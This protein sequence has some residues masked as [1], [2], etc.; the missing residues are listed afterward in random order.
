MS[1]PCILL[2]QT[3]PIFSGSKKEKTG[4]YIKKLTGNTLPHSG[5]NR[6]NTLC[7]ASIRLYELAII[8][9]RP[10]AAQKRIGV[11]GLRN[12][13]LYYSTAR[14]NHWTIDLCQVLFMTPPVKYWL[15]L[16]FEFGTLLAILI[17][18]LLWHP[19]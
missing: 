1:R 9:D 10:L 16:G 4:S 7:L 19:S 18:W 15:I 11:A 8:N 3:S 12:P 14:A 6:D 5:G 13:L 17:L 2:I